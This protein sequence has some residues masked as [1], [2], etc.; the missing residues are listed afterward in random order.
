[1]SGGCEKKFG[2]GG[3]GSFSSGFEGKWSAVVILLAL[4]HII[5]FVWMIQLQVK[6]Y[7]LKQEINK[8][9]TAD[10]DDDGQ[11]PHQDI[12]DDTDDENAR[13]TRTLHRNKCSRCCKHLKNFCQSG[14]VLPRSARR[15]GAGKHHGGI[16]Q[17]RGSEGM[18]DSVDDEELP[19]TWTVDID[20]GRSY[21][22][23]VKTK[24]A[25]R[26]KKNGF[27]FIYV[28]MQP[29]KMNDEDEDEDEQNTYWEFKILHESGGSKNVLTTTRSCYNRGKIGCSFGSSK[30][31]MSGMVVRELKVGDTLQ[32]VVNEGTQWYSSVQVQTFGAFFI[33]H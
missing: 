21:M 15:V 23:F 20:N 19:G 32:V 29:H 22:E 4:L 26:I 11:E 16:V 27:Y 18:G 12:F 25:I 14:K 33:S 13:F 9:R 6:V 5:T 8:Y 3:G 17:L 30:T 31:T 28:Q 2:G 24:G 7:E 10:N 1:M